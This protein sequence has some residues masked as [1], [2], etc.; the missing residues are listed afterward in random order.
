MDEDDEDAEIEKQLKKEKEVEA[1]MSQSLLTPAAAR[2]HLQKVWYT[3]AIVVVVD[4]IL[5]QEAGSI[6][7][8]SGL[9]IYPVHVFV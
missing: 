8:L 6:H 3:V 7:I 5:F 4:K 9:F 2:L 1:L